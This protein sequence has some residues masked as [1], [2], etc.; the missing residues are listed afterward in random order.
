MI[1]RPPKGGGLERRQKALGGNSTS[2]K[3]RGRI[4]GDRSLG[5]QKVLWGGGKFSPQGVPGMGEGGTQ[6]HGPHS[7]GE[8]RWL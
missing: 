1:T 6:P 8:G 2:Q 7:V 4:G 5:V 3:R